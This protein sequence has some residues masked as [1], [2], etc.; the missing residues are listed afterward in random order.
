MK[1]KL[2]YVI[3]EDSR[4]GEG[5]RFVLRLAGYES[6]LFFDEATAINWF[7][8]VHHAEE[9]LCLLFN[10]PQDQ[11]RTAEIVTSLAL[12]KVALPALLVQREKAHAISPPLSGG[13]AGEVF[14]CE[15]AGVMQLLEHLTATAFA[16]MPAERHTAAPIHGG[17]C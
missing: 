8:Y 3:D 9:P 16:A 7:K 11:M 5:L 15:P 4:R 13:N 14:V 17:R 6:C 12:S 2:V 1:K 10:N